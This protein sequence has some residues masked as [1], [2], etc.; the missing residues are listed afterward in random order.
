MLTTIL[1]VI[2]FIVIGAVLFAV[3]VY[4]GRQ[5]VPSRSSGG[6]RLTFFQCDLLLILVMAVGFGLSGLLALVIPGDPVI[7]RTEPSLS[8]VTRPFFLV[9]LGGPAL[10][11][12]VRWVRPT[13]DS[14]EEG[15]SPAWN[16][17][18]NAASLVGLIM[19]GDSAA[20]MALGLLGV[21]E[22]NPDSLAGSVVWGAVWFIHH[23]IAERH[24]HRG[25]RRVGVLGGALVGLVLLAF[26]AQRGLRHVL[27]GWI[28]EA[29]GGP[30]SLSESGDQLLRALVEVVIGGAIWARY[31]L[32]GGL[33]LARDALWRGYVV[34]V[35]VLGSLS[36][37]LTALGL[38]AASVLDWFLGGGS[39][40]AA[41][42]FAEAPV[43]LG[44]LIV[45][46]AVWAYHRA[47]VR[48]EPVD[49]SEV[50]RV[51]DYTAAGAGLAAAVIGGMGVI[52]AVIQVLAS[53][54]IT[55]PGERSDL[56]DALALVLVGV[57]VW[58][59]YWSMVQDHRAAEREP[60]VRSP[61]RRVYLFVVF[62]LG[63]VVVLFALLNVTVAFLIE[64]LKGDLGA[65][66]L[67]D[68]RTQVGVIVAVGAA[69]GYHR[70]IRRQDRAVIAAVGA[71][72]GGHRTIRRQ[73]RAQ[74]EEAAV[75]SVTLVGSG[76]REL[77]RAVA[78]RT[79]V[80]LQ[81][82]E[83]PDM[84]VGFSRDEVV[85][86]IESAEHEQ[87]L[88]V[89]RPEGPEVIPWPAGA[90]HYFV[91]AE[92]PLDPRVVVLVGSGSRGL[93]DAVA[94][95]TGAEL[96]LFERPDMDVGF[97]RDE[98]VAAIESAEHEHLLIVARPEGP[99][100]MPLSAPGDFLLSFLDP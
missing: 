9:I 19:G 2:G 91:E 68:V 25:H 5:P 72:V 7:A 95:Q 60:E 17:Y 96:W 88:I 27:L 48:T 21:E 59:R 43:S 93:A 40:Q 10:F 90:H 26:G 58:W 8:A 73:D 23:R 57:L 28:N 29:A 62:G 79:D 81:L 94:E 53:A 36:I 12:V 63:A 100:V 32:F 47:V 99:E 30:A 4:D 16:F 51:H 39:D 85:A 11:A 52:D 6:W 34:L 31:W 42:H 74:G 83:R 1:P 86:A 14:P 64:L 56:V 67:Y 15:T 45:S 18:L 44:F 71:E 65:S 24:G 70:T 41:V 78:L 33:R 22:F 84:E 37:A 82:F 20:W 75:R 13:R 3:M 76:G 87:L 46:G 97:S 98:V 35:G 66:T 61:T 89:A 49:R 92:V 55:R 50:D 54:G 77:A 80:K 38:L 69:A